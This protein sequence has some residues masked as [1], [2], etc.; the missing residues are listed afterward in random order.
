MEP[1]KPIPEFITKP[2]PE[3]VSKAIQNKYDDSWS[4]V[5]YRGLGQRLYD[6]QQ[7]KLKKYNAKLKAELATPERQAEKEKCLQLVAKHFES[8]EK[9]HFDIQ[10]LK[11]DIENKGLILDQVKQRINKAFNPDPTELTRQCDRYFHKRLLELRKI[12]ADE[13]Q[14][15]QAIENCITFDEFTKLVDDCLKPKELD[16]NPF[17]IGQ[18]EASALEEPVYMTQSGDLRSIFFYDGS[19][20]ERRITETPAGKRIYDWKQHFY[21]K[22]GCGPTKKELCA[23]IHEL[24]GD[25]TDFIELSQDLRDRHTYIIG[26][27]GSGKTTL[28]LNM[29]Y[30]DLKNGA[31]LG[32]IAPEQE[33]LTEQILPYIPEHRIDDVIY[34]NPADENPVPFNPLNLEPHEDP[35]LK[36]DEVMTIFKRIIG[37]EG[38]PRIDEILRQAFYALLNTPNTTLLDIPK[39]LNRDDP[40]YRH[41]IISQLQDEYCA[42][43]WRD[44]FPQFDK[45]AHLPILYRVSPFT[46]DKRIRNTLCRTGQSLDFRQL[47]DTGK[48]VL[49]NLSD[50]ILG[51]QNS[52][53]LGQL[54]VSQF[55]LAVASRANV[56]QEQRR[57][58]YLYIDEFQTFTNTATSSYEKIL[59]RARKYRL[60]LILAHQQTGQIPGELLRDIFG[61]VSTMIS[62]TVSH[63]DATK[64]SKEFLI[65]QDSEELKPMPLEN[66]VS[67]QI[68]ETYCKL[69]QESFKVK[70]FPTKEQPNFDTAQ[71]IINRSREL[72]VTGEPTFTT[73][74]E[75][76]PESGQ[77]DKPIPAGKPKIKPTGRI[78]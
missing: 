76:P 15:K 62:F 78:G 47:M 25:S 48:V 26:K 61:N 9:R 60:A 59:S 49:F 70:T 68:G 1:L 54:I 57:R 52:Q 35:D 5:Y 44:V 40:D 31:G 41:K 71:Q 24:Y 67:L 8:L 75:P 58:F 43:F 65:K 11:S 2:F 55:Q 20:T 69:G 28:M 12:N 50:G 51:E 32:V 17:T 27:S 46:R 34:F 63:N 10:W 18:R 53:L 72:F 23:K 29:I 74:P 56:P 64:L 66:L 21:A 13:N 77:P 22:H 33:M 14:L 39:L 45:N 42:H 7:R 38:T 36:A 37:S 30:Q 73:K 3:R 16:A 6:K 19:Y 4:A